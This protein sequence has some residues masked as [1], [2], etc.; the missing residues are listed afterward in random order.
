MS[1]SGTATFGTFTYTSG[2]AVET[3]RTNLIAEWGAIVDGGAA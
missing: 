1:Y 2:G 3:A